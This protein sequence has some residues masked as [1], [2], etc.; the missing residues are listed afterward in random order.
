M[1]DYRRESF[2]KWWIEARK[3]VPTAQRRR[4]KNW[5]WKGWHACIQTEMQEEQAYREE[6]QR[7]LNEDAAKG[8]DIRSPGYWGDFS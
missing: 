5:A 6:F 1:T 3:H 8:I 4:L 2:D 7:R